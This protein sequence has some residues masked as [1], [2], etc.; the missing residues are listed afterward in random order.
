MT[1]PHM[2]LKS[3]FRQRSFSSAFR[4][5]SLMIT[6]RSPGE[7]RPIA[8]HSVANRVHSRNKEFRRRSH[9]GQGT[10]VIGRD[11]C[12]HSKQFKNRNDAVEHPIIVIHK[13]RM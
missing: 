8:I 4:S 5:I 13:E 9:I 6:F 7:F 11:P 3:A 12:F 2:R 1:A 10:S